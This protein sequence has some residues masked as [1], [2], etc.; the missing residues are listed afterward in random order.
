MAQKKIPDGVIGIFYWHNLSGCTI[1]LG[2]TQPLT[3]MSTR[4]VS[5]GYRHFH[6][7]IVL[8]SGSFNLLEPSGPVKACN[9]NGIAFLYLYLTRFER[10]LF[11]LS[12]PY[13]NGTWYIA[14]VLCQLLPGF[15]VPLQPNWLKGASRWFHYTDILWCT[16][17]HY[18]DI[19]W[20]TVNK[21]LS[22]RILLI[23]VH[24]FQKN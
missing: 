24:R 7:L 4:N 8:K 3:E 16:V 15:R 10:Y 22:L 18:T 21:T 23:S 19:L 6:V 5:W 12:R 2:S 9:G 20:C 1:S 17:S 14:C 13:T 11:I